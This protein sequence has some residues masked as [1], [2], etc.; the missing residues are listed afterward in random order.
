MAPGWIK[1]IT[2]R[3]SRT[4][5]EKFTFCLALNLSALV[6]A[7]L[8]SLTQGQYGVSVTDVWKVLCNFLFRTSFD[9]PQNAVNVV[10]LIRL[11]R[12]AAAFIVGSCLSVAGNTFQSTFNNQLVSPDVLGVSAGACVGAAVAILIGV[13]SYLIGVFAFFTGIAAVLLSLLLPRLFRSNKT[14]TLVLSG[15]IVGSLMNSI[16]GLIKFVSDREEKLSE[17]TFWIMGALSGMS[18]AK[19]YTVLPIYLTAAVGIFCL[20]WKINVLSLGEDE[21]QT[22]GLN[23]RMY[24]LLVIVFSTLLTAVSVSLSG[25]VGW[26]GLVV[27]HISRAIVGGDNCYAI[28]I[29]FLFG[30][31]FMIL[32]DMLARNLSVD[33]IPLSIITGL[34]GTV[35]YSIVL[36]RRGRDIHE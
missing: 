35:I 9:V 17:I 14:V 24:R 33:E 29:S 16:I 32:V 31:S 36:I 4:D 5:R 30:G 19:I 3:R 7:V 21:A 10:G 25:N 13:S 2:T 28:P 34:I 11:P 15:I 27:P 20:R 26:I 8:L 12:T 6:A 22:L 23:Y 1:N 18:A